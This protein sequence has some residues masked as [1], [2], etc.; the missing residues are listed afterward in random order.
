METRSLSRLLHSKVVAVYIV[1]SSFQSMGQSTF[2]VI[3]KSHSTK[4]LFDESNANSLI[5]QVQFH[6]KRGAAFPYR[7]TDFF[8]DSIQGIDKEIVSLLPSDVALSE[9]LG[10]K[11]FYPLAS[12][13]TGEDSIVYDPETGFETVVTEEVQ[14]VLLTYDLEDI[15]RII[16]FNFEPLLKNREQTVYSEKRIGF[17]KKYPGM[18]KYVITLSMSFEEFFRV[19]APNGCLNDLAKAEK[20]FSKKQELLLDFNKINQEF[21][22]NPE[23]TNFFGIPDPHFGLFVFRF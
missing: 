3:D 20:K 1:L 10:A 22:I 13:V 6:L 19:V 18:E 17:A 12:V 2:F 8:L 7:N 16:I 9:V 15:S 23:E 4:G 14:E 21:L 11:F 5:S